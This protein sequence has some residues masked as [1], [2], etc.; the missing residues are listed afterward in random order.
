MDARRHEARDVGHVRQE[1]GAHLVGDG[2]EPSKS[3]TRG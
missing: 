1:K 2:A 3:I